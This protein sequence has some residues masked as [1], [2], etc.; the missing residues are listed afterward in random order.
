MTVNFT[1]LISNMLFACFSLNVIITVIY[2]VEKSV[3]QL[4]LLVFT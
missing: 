4:K 3:K 1:D 2:K